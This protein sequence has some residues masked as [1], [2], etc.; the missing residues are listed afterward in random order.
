MNE[1]KKI[2]LSVVM[3][4]LNEART[5]ES[6]IK[7]A[8]L[9]MKEIGIKGE[10]VIAD[11]GSSDGSQEIAKKANARV[12]TILEKGYGSALKGGIEA[13]YGEF[14]IMGDSD[15]SYDFL[16]IAPFVEKLR[17]GYDLVMGNRFAGGIAK[18][19]M[20]PLHKYL[21]NPVLSFIGKLFFPSEINDFHCGLRG[22]SKIAYKKLNLNTSGMEFASEMV[23]K[24]TLFNMKVCEV[25]T[26]LNTDGRDR[27]PHLRSWHDGWR[28]LRFLLIYSPRWLFLYP[29]ILMMFLGLLLGIPLTFTQIHIGDFILDIHTLLFAA[30]FFVVGYQSIWLALITR[31]HA[32]KEGFLPQKNSLDNFVQSL[33]LEKG[34]L[35]G[36]ILLLL[37]LAFAL[38]SLFKWYNISEM[39]AFNPQLGLRL[40]I[41]S[42]VFLITGMQTI[43]ST[44]VVSILNIKSNK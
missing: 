36:L 41:P 32:A 35:I 4:C 3:P 30:A 28:H 20:P 6:C 25:P 5:I 34:I 2:E 44:F 15:E 31:I 12:V 23:V 39:K 8:Q 16:G 42:I 9:A 18:G 43:L 21:G 24:A 17:Q 33:S 29:G 40:V 37:G 27:P 7:K 22:I 26:T 10:V 38:F 13:A 1:E 19:A 14:V 11:N